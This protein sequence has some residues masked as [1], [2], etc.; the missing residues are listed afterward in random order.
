MLGPVVPGP[1]KRAL[2]RLAVAACRALAARGHDV[3]VLA[4]QK[5]LERESREGGVVVRRVLARNVLPQTLTDPIETWQHARELPEEDSTSF[6][7]TSRR[8]QWVCDGGRGERRSCSCS[9]AARSSAS[10]AGQLAPGVRK[11]S[12]YVLAPPL[13]RL[14][15]QAVAAAE[16][17]L[18]LSDFSRSLLLVDHER[19]DG[20]AS[21]RSGARRHG[22]LLPGD[23]RGCPAPA[24]GLEAEGPVLLTVRRLEPRM[25]IDRLL[26]PALPLLG[27]DDVTLVVAGT[28]SLAGDLPRLAAELLVAERVLFVGR[29]ADDERLADWY[30]AADLS[31]L[32]TSAY[33]GFGMA[34]AR[35]SRAG[36]P[37]SAPQS[38]PPRAA[39]PARRPPGRSSADPTA[40]ASAIGDALG[41]A[42][43]TDFGVR[44]R[45]YAEQ[46]FAA[47]SAI[48]AWE[49]ALAEVCR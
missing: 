12:T 32:P 3:A 26:P 29:V 46:R 35:G 7:P 25:G 24:L 4:P 15:R 13:G 27:R 23:G 19:L 11:L 20:S 37:W 39:R 41:F 22:P 33:E 34:A 10:C 42:T 18:V 30:Q 17:I 40:L 1:A 9:S 8:P 28:G 5:R 36:R 48:S 38:A 16:Q 2:A 45:D 21:P 44:C 14:E 43:T 47:G 49:E 6:S 31:V